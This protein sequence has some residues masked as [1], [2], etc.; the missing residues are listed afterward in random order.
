L[1]LVVYLQGLYLNQRLSF[2]FC[3]ASRNSALFAAAQ[4]NTLQHIWGNF[5]L[6]I[7]DSNSYT[8]FH[9]MG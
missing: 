1:V 2:T 8:C 5:L 6:C 4:V 9:F 3:K 7:K